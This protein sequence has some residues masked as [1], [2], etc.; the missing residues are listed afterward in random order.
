MGKPTL[1]TNDH[2]GHEFDTYVYNGDRIE[3]SPSFI[4]EVCIN[5]Y[6]K[7]GFCVLGSKLYKSNRLLRVK[8]KSIFK[9]YKNY[10]IEKEISLVGAPIGFIKENNL[11]IYHL[12]N[13]RKCKKHGK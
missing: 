6:W 2:S 4:Y 12:N 7:C 13:K 3:I 5:K 9:Y 11:P 1:Q 10:V 8:H